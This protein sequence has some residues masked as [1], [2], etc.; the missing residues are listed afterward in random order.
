MD[1]VG[2][3]CEL[4]AHPPRQRPLAPV[5]KGRQPSHVEQSAASGHVVPARHTADLGGEGQVLGHGQPVV[6]C[7]TLGHV[8]DLRR[9]LRS[10]VHRVVTQDLAP[11]FAGIEDRREKLQERRLSG[12]V[13]PDQADDLANTDLDVDVAQRQD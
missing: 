9:D 7:E 12:T 4:L 6:E 8:A 11:T 1:Q 3:E 5:E 10:L 13:R 2:A